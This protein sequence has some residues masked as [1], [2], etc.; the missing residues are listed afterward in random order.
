MAWRKVRIV[1][2]GF[3][4]GEE[5]AFR[6]QAHKKVAVRGYRKG[7]GATGEGWIVLG[8]APCGCDGFSKRVW[9]T[10]ICDFVF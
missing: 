9:Q 4:I 1:I 8:S 5:A 6:L 3:T 2:V 7:E 10:C